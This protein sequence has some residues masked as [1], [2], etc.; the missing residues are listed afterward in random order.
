LITSAF[1]ENPDELTLDKFLFF[2]GAFNGREQTA[3]WYMENYQII[4]EAFQANS[5]LIKEYEANQNVDSSLRE[6]IDVHFS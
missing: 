3:M 2:A 6:F 4:R 5:R 1:K